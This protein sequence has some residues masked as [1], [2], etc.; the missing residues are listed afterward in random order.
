M[1]YNP[2]F[3]A[4]MDYCMWLF[5]QNKFSGPARMIARGSEMEEFIKHFTLNGVKA[6]TI[7][8]PN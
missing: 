4:Y 6:S 2:F 8:K 3:E 1:I 7:C 5:L